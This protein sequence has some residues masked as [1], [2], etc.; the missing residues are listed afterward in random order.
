MLICDRSGHT[1]I[2]IWPKTTCKLHKNVL[3]LPKWLYALDLTFISGCMQDL[4]IDIQM[5]GKFKMFFFFSIQI[6]EFNIY[7]LFK[8]RGGSYWR[9]VLVRRIMVDILTQWLVRAGICQR[10]PWFNR[11]SQFIFLFTGLV[12]LFEKIHR[13]FYSCFLIMYQ[14]QVVEGEAKHY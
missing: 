11:A 2:R 1:I 7:L 12:S 5:V 10:D 9:G 14:C 4:C 3:H 6:Y 8:W 13:S